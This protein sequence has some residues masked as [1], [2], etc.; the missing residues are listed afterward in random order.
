MSKVSQNKFG[1]RHAIVHHAKEH[2]IR[3]ATRRFD[4]HRNTVR[5]WLRR[6]DAGERT[7]A[8][9]SKRPHH[10]PNRTPDSIEKTVVEARKKAP[11]FGAPRLIDA[12]GL[13]LGKG[14]AHRI[15]RDKNLVRK[16]R[17]KH[18]RK[19][20]LRAIKA[21]HAPLTRLQMDTKYLT[22]IPNYYAPMTQLGLPRFQY[23]IRD[24]STG[25]LFVA[26]A[27]ELS[28]TYATLAINGLLEHLK[29]HGVD[30]AQIQVRTD[31]G[32]EFDGDTVHYREDG[33][34]RGIERLGATH[35]FNPPA[36]PNANAD[37][38]SSHNTIELEF[39]DIESFSS[40][41]QFMTAA[42]TYQHYFNFGRKN[43]SRANKTP[44]Q[45]LREK[46][47]HLSPRALLY[48]PVF[49]SHEVGQLLSGSPGRL[50]RK[51]ARFCPVW[52]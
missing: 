17:R 14:A 28:K 11:C 45:L 23:T 44:A 16:P 9:H 27:S 31:L 22:D 25:A 33:F 29:A 1:L 47:P 42:S 32:A 15:L 40:P 30:P 21:A 19:A 24:E 37:V 13:K 34:H 20:D 4:C 2:G 3:D 6:Y 35:R 10:S 48:P 8:D 52:Q 12:F 36:R 7:L 38:E 5:L 50:A 41:A 51:A 39:F 43:R 26:Y 49:L 46:A 18:K